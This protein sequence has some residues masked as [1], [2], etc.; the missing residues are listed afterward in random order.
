MPDDIALSIEYAL[1]QKNISGDTSCLQEKDIDSLVLQTL[2]NVG[3]GRVAE[4]FQKNSVSPS[5]LFRLPASQ[6]SPFLEESLNIHG[7]G[8]ERIVTKVVNTMEAIGAKNAT[9][10]MISELAKHFLQQ[11]TEQLT[12]NVLK[13]P[14]FSPDKAGS[15]RFME[16]ETGLSPEIKKYFDRRILTFHPVNLHIFPSLRLNI[17]LTGIATDAGLEAPLT[18]LSLGPELIRLTA[19]IDQICLIV[20]QLCRKKGRG[21]DTPI[22][23]ILTLGDASVFTRDWMACS[24]LEAQEACAVSICEMILNMLTRQPIKMTC[25]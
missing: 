4:F 13:R 23:L 21:S 25:I 1:R 12:A 8:L 2:K 10:E 5:G 14:D 3:Y 17:R 19:V 24:T 11:S 15:I 7:A 9:R 6:V 16:L 18:E 22:K 20:D